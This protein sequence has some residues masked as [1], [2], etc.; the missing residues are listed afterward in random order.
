MTKTFRAE[1]GAL[2]H[3]SD[4]VALPHHYLMEPLFTETIGEMVDYGA[5]FAYL[6]RR[7]GY[8]NDGWDN[9]KNLARYILTTPE[10]DL[11]LQVVP[12]V[13]NRSALHFTF[14]IP[15]EAYDEIHR[16]EQAPLDAWVERA[17]TWYEAA[18]SVPDW[19]P[20]WME[21]ASAFVARPLDDWK[22]AFSLLSL[23]ADGHTT[24]QPRKTYGAFFEE[25]MNAY[26]AIEPEP[27]RA[28]YPDNWHEWPD[29]DREK[30]YFRAAAISMGDLQRPVRVRGARINA[31]GRVLDSVGGYTLKE[32]AVAGWASG[33]MGNA[34]PRGAYDLHGLALTLGKGNITRGTKDI[35]AAFPDAVAAMNREDGD[36]DHPE[37]VEE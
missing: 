3:G 32:P 16:I 12:Y 24:E 15:Y 31:R 7:F 17:T 35:L 36:G 28:T 18:H 11:F 23:F 30:A 19:M 33:I 2:P 6:F 4:Y 25:V 34:D 14:L 27:A 5:L 13:G 29:D 1:L 20:D 9:Y 26:R 22:D 8:P 10:P 37:D 21:E